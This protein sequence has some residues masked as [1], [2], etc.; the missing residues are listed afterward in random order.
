MKIGID[1][2]GS[3]IAIGIVDKDGKLIG[4]EV[5][6]ISSANIKSEKDAKELILNIIYDEIEKLLEKYDYEISDISK[7]LLI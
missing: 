7:I 6:D 4:K 3:H 5:R 1:I 2:G